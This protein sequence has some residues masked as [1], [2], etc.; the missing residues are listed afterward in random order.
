MEP[1]K[2]VS[3]EPLNLIEPA[4]TPIEAA[5]LELDVSIDKCLFSLKQMRAS[6]LYLKEH[7]EH[8]LQLEALNNIESLIDEAM[9]P[10]LAEICGEFNYIADG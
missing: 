5:C 9:I 6:L 1:P 7:L 4:S 3:E 2:V 8:P 10:Y